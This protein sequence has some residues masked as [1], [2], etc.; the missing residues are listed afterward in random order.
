MEAVTKVTCSDTVRITAEDLGIDA[1]FGEYKETRTDLWTSI[2]VGFDAF[3]T[4][5]T[6]DLLEEESDA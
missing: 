5:R 1:T 2:L 3:A 6:D 4:V